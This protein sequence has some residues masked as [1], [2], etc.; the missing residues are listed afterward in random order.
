MSREIIAQFRARAA[1][2]CQQGAGYPRGCF[3][4]R[5]GWKQLPARLRPASDFASNSAFS[6]K[7]T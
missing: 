4:P 6:K 3:W 7:T 5:P 1:F 2:F